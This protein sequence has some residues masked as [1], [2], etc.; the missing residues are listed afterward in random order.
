M[1]MTHLRRLRTAVRASGLL[2]GCVAAGTGTWS[3]VRDPFR[4]TFGPLVEHGS[5][6]LFEVTF[7]D[8]LTAFCAAVLTACVL[9]LLVGTL[10]AV[11]SH[12]VAELSPRST[13]AAA[14]SMATDHGWPRG[15]R[16]AVAAALGVAVVAGAAGPALGDPS[17]PS[18]G[19]AHRT[20]ARAGKPTGVP[21]GV[22]NGL[23]V[24]DR[25]A[26]AATAARRPAARRPIS[27][28]PV[29]RPEG[30]VVVH[31]GD[32]LWSISADL[33]PPRATDR[34]ITEAWHR[35]H[36]ANSRR[37]G[38]DPDLILP[39]TPLAVPE[40]STPDREDPS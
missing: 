13:A 15:L 4:R 34:D 36:R 11:A 32:S 16:R 19:H 28:R 8:V 3:V 29:V 14:L 1:T 40:R 22:L 9:W 5:A 25:T 38:P 31:R 2:A 10:L 7:E 17:E 30:A 12:V 23:A 27:Q 37:V 6:G 24:P 35:L 33:L 18:T 39:G 26:G 20:S 21:T